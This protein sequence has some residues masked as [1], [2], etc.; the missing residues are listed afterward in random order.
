MATEIGAVSD[1]SSKG[2]PEIISIVMLPGI[3]P[4]DDMLLIPGDALAQLLL[5]EI[6]ECC[7]SRSPRGANCGDQGR[8]SALLVNNKCK[9]ICVSGKFKVVKLLSI[10][11]YVGQYLKGNLLCRGA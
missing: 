9:S 10:S 11:R 2:R 4:A 8:R 3:E 7:L 6:S 1:I 5:N